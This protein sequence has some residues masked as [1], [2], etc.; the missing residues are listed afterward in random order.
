MTMSMYQASVPVFIS[1]FNNLT[2][3]LK[4]GEKF[5]EMKEIKPTVLIHSRLAPDMFPLSRQIQ[6]ASDF[7]RRCIARL[8]DDELTSID[9][10]EKTFPELYDRINTTVAYLESF[11]PEQIDGT[12]DKTITLEIRGMIF[13]YSGM[14]L[15]WFFSM[16]NFYFHVTTAYNILRHNGVDIGKLDFFGMKPPL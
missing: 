13:N 2:H 14:D 8:S 5:A 6:F 15:L 3:V 11:R 10:K 1:G 9:D 4:K 16:P 12:E 7:S